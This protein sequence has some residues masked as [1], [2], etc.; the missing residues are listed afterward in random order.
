LFLSAAPIE[1]S[2]KRDDIPSRSSLLQTPNQDYRDHE[3]SNVALTVTNYGTL[4]TGAIISP[5]CDG[6]ACPSCQYPRGSQLEY[7]FWG[8]VWVGGIVGEDTLVSVGLDGWFAGINELQPDEAPGGEIIEISNNPAYPNFSPDAESDWDIICTFTDTFTDPAITGNDPYSDHPHYPLPIEYVRTSY[9]W[10]DPAVDDFIMV[11][12]V[13]TNLGDAPINDIW[14]G[15]YF[16]C[17]VLHVSTSSGFTD[18]VTGLLYADLGDYIAYIIDN[19]GDPTFGEWT[20]QS[21]R[22]VIGVKLHQPDP[23]IAQVNYN[24][25]VSNG[26]AAQD[27]GPRQAGTMEDPF[28][29]F[30][31][32]MGTPTGDTIK[33]YMLSHDEKDYDQVLTA[34]DHTGDGWLPPPEPS[35]AADIADGWDSRFLYSFGPF[36]LAPG[37][38]TEIYYSILLGGDLHTS[39]SNYA[40]NFDALDPSTYYGNLDFSGLLAAAAAADSVYGVLTSSCGDANGNG[41]TN[42]SDAVYIINWVF[43]GGARPDDLEM[44]DANCDGSTNITDAV[45]IVN[46]IFRG[47][48]APCC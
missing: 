15:L 45:Y 40:D 42:I 28:R 32:H 19:D 17:D 29:S 27:W 36:N 46:W 33:Y 34:I 11:K 18:D 37:E 35:R 24:W 4:G 8:G 12:G 39:P 41:K 6:E 14:I 25:W 3:E 7:L 30:G 16:D 31:A 38:S 21:P 2:D 26:A 13:L 10:S 43:K 5:M 23:E 22:S 44:A 1:K 47:G 9:S 48:P 20:S